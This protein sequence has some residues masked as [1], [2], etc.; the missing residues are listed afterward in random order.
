MPISPWRPPNLDPLPDEGTP[1]WSNEDSAA[2]FAAHKSKNEEQLIPSVTNVESVWNAIRQEAFLK[3]YQEGLEK[4]R[5]A[6]FLIGESDGRERGRSSGYKDG[7]QDGFAEATAKIRHIADEL[8]KIIAVLNSMPDDLREDLIQLAYDTSVRLF[9]RTG[10]DRE[11][12]E[13]AIVDS[14]G[15]L[16]TA[17]VDIVLR[18]PFEDIAAWEHALGSTSSIDARPQLTPD[19]GLSSGQA[20]LE[21]KGIRIDISSG[22]RHALV[23]RALGLMSK[24]ASDL[25][26]RVG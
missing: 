5:D 22:A 16:P 23:R 7:Y 6:G 8:S 26:D 14:L 9:G 11:A 25:T 17:G 3:G 1:T 2:V 18:V 15:E 21:I 19:T 13:K 12:I 10:I 24:P 4:G 20:F